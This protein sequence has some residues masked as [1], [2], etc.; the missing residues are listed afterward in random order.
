MEAARPFEGEKTYR[1]E[2]LLAAPP[3]LVWPF[4]SDTQRVNRAIGLAPWTFREIPDPRGGSQRKGSFTYLGMAVEWDE[5]P[6]EWVAPR[7]MGVVRNYTRGPLDAV[8]SHVTLDPHAGGTRI[9][10]TVGVRTKGVLG[11]L[12][13]ALE[14]GSKMRSGLD[15]VYRGF[16]DFLRGQRAASFPEEAV[17]LSDDGSRLLERARGALVELGFEDALVARLIELVTKEPD[18]ELARVRPFALARKWGADRTDVLRLFLHATKRGLL[19]MSWDLVCPSCKGAK[20]TTTELSRLKTE[21]HCESCNV[22]FDAQFDESVE[23]TF[24][25]SAA[26][27]PITVAEYCVGGPGNTRHLVAQARIAPAKTVDLALAL[28]P[29][30]YLLRGPKKPGELTVEV[31]EGAPAELSV[32]T[33]RFPARTELAPRAVLRVTNEDAFEHTV[34]LE[35]QAWKEDVA[36]GTRVT[37]LQEFRDMF[38]SQVF[39]PDTRVGISSISLLFTDLKSSTAMYE[40]VGD[41]VAFALVRDHFKL[42]FESVADEQGGLVKTIGDAVMASFPQPANALRAA[43]RMHAEIA[44]FNE[45]EKP[46]FP[47]RLK[48]GLHAGPCIAVNLN[49]RLDYFGT[50]VNMA[51][52]IQNESAGDDI[53]LL[54]SLAK[55][56]DV[57]RVLDASAGT[58]EEFEAELKGL[59]GK[60]RLLRFVPA[61]GTA[62]MLPVKRVSTRFKKTNLFG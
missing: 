4:V 9:V 41:A 22:K 31:K 18:R 46:A 50:T 57:A 27:R 32:A 3:E 45:H 42:L 56:P 17:S 60:F 8:R 39:A 20:E 47:V 38:S 29:G 35:R 13:T 59:T 2:W 36:T 37:C 12:A 55:D 11:G 14:V 6:Y 48:I 25:P 30:L 51:A 44:D 53:V 33:G 26:V 15:K 16:D 7:E 49:E 52:R 28:E 24:R 21:V 34:A 19:E 61:R 54:D 23:V 10:H 58:R 62:G 40:K 43:I 5:N 1:W